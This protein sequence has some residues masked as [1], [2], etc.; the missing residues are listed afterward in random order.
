MDIW[1]L[2]LRSAMAFGKYRARGYYR[3]MGRLVHRWNNCVLVGVVFSF[4]LV[5]RGEKEKAQTQRNANEPMES[6]GMEPAGVSAECAGD[7][8]NSGKRNR[9]PMQQHQADKSKL[10]IKY[11]FIIP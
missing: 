11:I 1:T 10:K 9:P 3:G 2:C 5:C 8:D 7:M 4:G 6:G